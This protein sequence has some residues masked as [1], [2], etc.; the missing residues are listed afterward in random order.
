MRVWSNWFTVVSS[1]WSQLLRYATVCLLAFWASSIIVRL[2]GLHRNFTHYTMMRYP[3]FWFAAIISYS[4][5]VGIIVYEHGIDIYLIYEAVVVL[6]PFLVALCIGVIVTFLADAFECMRCSQSS[7]VSKSVRKSN[8]MSSVFDNDEQ[9]IT[10]ILDEKP[11]CYP[12]DDMFGHAL[13]ARKIAG[14]LIKE[15]ASSV[16]II[17][18]YGSGKSSTINLVEYY[19]NNIEELRSNTGKQLSLISDNVICCRIDGWGRKP[20]SVAPKILAMAIEKVK[21]HI[22]CLSVVSLP[23][24]YRKALA[25][26]KSWGGAVLSALF[27]ASHDPVEQISKLNDILTA[28]N[29]RLIIF[30]EDLDRN[31][32][33]E[34]IR[35]EMPALL[36]RLRGLK[37]IT[38]VLAI[39]TEKQYSDILIRICDHVEAIA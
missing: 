17:G 28:G 36:D 37:K 10:W 11:I 34:I 21:C 3:P 16:G 8:N 14:L 25:G 39:G 20:G 6:F 7:E 26:G 19:L 4:I 31:I 29:L 12:E 5:I 9:L 38:F 23:E 30:L 35:D 1:K 2:G 18:S 13:S 32:S 27:Q 22:D 24:N 15:K 33:D